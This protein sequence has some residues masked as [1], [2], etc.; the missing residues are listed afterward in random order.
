MITYIDSSNKQA[1]TV[2]FEKASAKLGLLPIEKE[3]TDENGETKIVKYKRVESNGVWSTVECTD[4][5]F[6]ADGNFL[7]TKNGEKVISKGISSLNDYYQHITQLTQLAVGTGRTGSDPYFLRLPLDEPFIEINADTRAVTVPSALSQVAI[8]GDKL[9]EVVFFRI[10]RYYDAVDLNTRQIYI[11][12]ETADGTKGISRDFLRDV[13]SEKDKIIFGWA[14]GDEL[15]KVAGT[16]RFS[17]RFVE[18]TNRE[19]ESTSVEGSTG[20]LYSFSSSPATLTVADSL[21]YSLFEDDEQLQY[22]T[23]QTENNIGTI[24]AYLEDSD[25]DSADETA[26]ELAAIPVLVRDMDGVEGATASGEVYVANLQ[27]GG[28]DEAEGMLEIVSE[29]YSPDAG[30]INYIYGRKV[31]EDSGTQGIVAKIKFIEVSDTSNENVTYYEKTDTG[32]YTPVLASQIEADGT[33][34]ER[35]AYCIAKLPGY[36]NV[37]ASN[38]VSGK[39]VNKATGKTL[40]IPYAAKPE[41]ETKMAEKFV[42]SEIEYG[43]EKDDS[44]DQSTKADADKSNIKVTKSTAGSATTVLQPAISAEDSG[45]KGLTYTWYKSEDIYDTA[46]EKAEVVEGATEATLEVSEPGCYALKVDNQFNNDHT[47]T[48]L[49]D[50]GVC[51]VTNMPTLPEI[52]WDEF[53]N[54]LIAGRDNQPKLEISEVDTDTMSYEWHKITTDNS[55]LDPVATED[56]ENATGELKFADGKAYIPFSPQTEGLYYFLLTNELNGAKFIL[57][58]ATSYGVIDVR[59]A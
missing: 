53:E 32:E 10:D 48:E 34:Y 14:I 3:V 17:V 11:E 4:D 8:I 38:R 43:T 54:I 49:L 45:T 6:D 19:D 9:A 13:Q 20:L 16:I 37:T 5:D 30:S 18:W 35:V 25:P 52:A 22:V 33:Y 42:I 47:E 29:A 21:Q 27:G 1:Y 56:M 12:W 24:V 58:S 31:S 41:V 55:D 46:M 51:R 57:N 15:T 28:K 40:Y 36:Y 44:V 26:P 39:K 59:R 7:I 2:L 50:A 23:E